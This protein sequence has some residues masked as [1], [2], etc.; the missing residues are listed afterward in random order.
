MLAPAS[1]SASELTITPDR[2]SVNSKFGVGV[3]WAGSA[4]VDGNAWPYCD[5]N[6]VWL[7]AGKHVL[8]RPPRDA[9][10]P[11]TRLID[12]NGEINTVTATVRGL[13]LAY[14][15]EARAIAIL[16]RT[17]VTM[18]IDGVVTVMKTL[19]R[20]DATVVLLPAGS[21]HVEFVTQ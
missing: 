11:R 4:Y 14:K 7:P 3:R 8:T 18:R 6:F 10:L 17:P 16:D 13:D 19:K 9:A 12:F 1:A 2:T 20:R 21:H 15:A 5:G